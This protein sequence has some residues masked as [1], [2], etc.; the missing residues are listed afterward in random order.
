[1][2]RHKGVFYTVC[3]HKAVFTL[4]ADHVQDCSVYCSGFATKTE[5]P[6][7]WFD[8]RI[9]SLGVLPPYRWN[10][11]ANVLL[12]LDRYCCR[13]CPE[14]VAVSKA[15]CDNCTRDTWTDLPEQEDASVL[16]TTM[17]CAGLPRSWSLYPARWPLRLHR[18][19]GQSQFDAP[20]VHGVRWFTVLS[21]A[22]GYV[23]GPSR[24]GH[25]ITKRLTAVQW[26]R[27]NFDIAGW[28]FRPK[29]HLKYCQPW[30]LPEQFTPP[31][32]ILTLT[33]KPKPQTL[34]LVA[35]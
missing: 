19:H 9:R 35:Y 3:R 16:S 31:G 11:V 24:P 8:P 12:S 22:G 32:C 17:Y 2:C 1:M 7:V 18:L 26:R 27:N 20:R 10:I 5:Q 25:V 4:G 6:I 30:R 14:K 21:G 13:F 34:N 23:S 29:L 28:T 33:M 15:N